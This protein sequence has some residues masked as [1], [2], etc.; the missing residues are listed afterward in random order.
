MRIPQKFGESDIGA[1]DDA[2]EFSM[3]LA[4]ASAVRVG[5]PP[6]LSD[7]GLISI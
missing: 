6:L 5:H 3:L 4:F 1:A 2:V 7:N